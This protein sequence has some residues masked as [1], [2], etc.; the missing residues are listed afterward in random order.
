MI[1][2]TQTPIHPL[3]RHLPPHH[4]AHQGKGIEVV[5]YEPNRQSD[6]LADVQSK[7]YTRDI[8]GSD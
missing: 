6:T 7:V 1:K 5:I 4:E 8:F 2:L 3:H